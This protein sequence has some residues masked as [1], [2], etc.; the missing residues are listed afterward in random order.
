MKYIVT[1]VGTSLFTNFISGKNVKNILG[2]KYFDINIEYNR[3][4][5]VGAENYLNNDDRTINNA[6]SKI[7]TSLNHF[8]WHGLEF[9]QEHNC[10]IAIN[11]FNIN[12]D[13]SA[14]ISSLFK[15]MRQNEDNNDYEIHLIATDS[16]LSIL[17]AE[18]IRDRL[19]EYFS[20]K[21]K[22]KDYTITRQ[23]E[24]KGLNVNVYFEPQ[25]DY[26]KDLNANN[27]NSFNTGLRNLIVKINEKDPDKNNPNGSPQ[28]I[29]NM[30][31]GYKGLIPI[32]TLYSQLKRC[33]L[34]YQF[35]DSI[36][37]LRIP[38][39][40]IDIETSFFDPYI[41]ESLLLETQDIGT[42]DNRIQSIESMF[43]D[44]IEEV[45]I[46]ENN[47]NIIFNAFGFVLWEQYK[48]KYFIYIA[49]DKVQKLIENNKELKSYFSTELHKTEVSGLNGQITFEVKERKY[50]VYYKDHKFSSINGIPYFFIYRIS[51]DQDCP[52]HTFDIESEFDP[53]MIRTI[54]KT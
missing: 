33:E 14:E 34:C 16:T 50:C 6:K 7:K 44:I 47:R 2:D 20:G 54:P 35:D 3:L 9:D 4:K 23:N 41:Y 18:F 37:V 51:K 28:L 46:D 12:I 22:Y 48:N 5:N 39:I 53:K 24:H 38:Q 31:G 40:P 15:I 52:E 21:I 30:T 13:A 42:S 29:L 27:A 25:K 32:L 26:V 43:K 8:W 11:D 45:P 10:W 19:N 17:A 49:S 36:E 1:T